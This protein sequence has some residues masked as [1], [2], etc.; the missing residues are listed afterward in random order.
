VSRGP[1][2]GNVNLREAESPATEPLATEPSE[3][4][5]QEELAEASAPEP[6][7]AAVGI[8]APSPR[9]LS[10]I[11]WLR[12]AW[13]QLTSMRTAL[14]LLF[15]LAIASVPGSVLP[16]QGVDP[17][18][19]SQYYTAHPALAPILNKLSLFNVFAAPWFAAIYLLLFLSL[20]GCVLPRTFRLVG[21]ARQKPPRAPRYLGRLPLSASYATALTP[22][23]ALESGGRQLGAKRFRLRT[24][25]GWLS[26]EKG[27]LR[28]V[29]NLLFHIALLALLAS[30]GLGGIFGYKA[31]RL[32]VAGQSFADTPTALDTFH[33][34]R[35]VSANDLAPFS[36]R[37]NHFGATYVTS[38]SEQDQP[39]TFNAA[40]SYT[41]TPGAKVQHYDLQVNRPLV[42]DGVSVYLIG[43]GYAPEFTVTDGAGK[44][45]FSG[46]VPF[47]P[48][49][50]SGLT[51]EGVIKV[52]D[53]SPTQLGF[54]GVF[55][56]TA[57]DQNGQL[58]SVFPAPLQ[59]RVSLV[60]YAGNLGLNNG[61]AQS[62]YQ[63]DTSSMHRLAVAPS[64]L[65]VGQSI[66]L[67]HGAGKLTFT[68]YRQWISLAI[69]HDPGQIPAL[70][71]ALVA[72]GGLIL[73][74]MVRRRRVFLRAAAGPDGRTIVD[75]GG[76]ARSDAA[77]GF[78]VEFAELA[79]ELRTAQDGVTRASGDG[80]GSGSGSAPGQKTVSEP[81]PSPAGASVEQGGSTPV[82]S[83][84]D[85]ALGSAEGE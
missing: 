31:N 69:T 70:I 20:A 7:T 26:A 40:L 35:L 79:E 75:F 44:V 6:G 59:P 41:V 63:L 36:I 49:E 13:R 28:E 50:Q 73:S 55:L 80:S 45:V 17:S 29:G 1:A 10:L 82:S 38:G 46:P 53:A 54:A 76:L 85:Q 58:V 3:A 61:Q 14:I 16:Q 25:D 62:I 52:P 83:G 18:A 65:S 74:F 81:A 2:G 43:H 77:G 48:V 67:P 37:L 21:A 66:T 12:W 24:G 19:V 71:S 27:Y 47:I 56:P 42:I 22:A 68:G 64:P 5:V 84:N 72:L 39:L 51:S 60:S 78:E 30:V 57:A 11:G 33:P 4:E 34:G 8:P 9:G 32:L 15:L 23:Q